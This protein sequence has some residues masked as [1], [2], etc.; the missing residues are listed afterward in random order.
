MMTLKFIH[1]GWIIKKLLAIPGCP[2]SNT[3]ICHSIAAVSKH[4]LL[5]TASKRKSSQC[6]E[7]IVDLGKSTLTYDVKGNLT[8]Q[9]K[10]GK[11]TV[12]M[13]EGEANV[14]ACFILNVKLRNIMG[15]PF[16]PFGWTYWGTHQS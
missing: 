5:V 16:N 1:E 11:C 6:I 12:N 13:G 15:T 2:R 10:K 14:T 4:T 9:I 7:S 8:W 3:C